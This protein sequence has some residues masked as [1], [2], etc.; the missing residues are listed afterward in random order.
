[1]STYFEDLNNL[2]VHVACLVFMF[3][4]I[5]FDNLHEVVMDKCSVVGMNVVVLPTL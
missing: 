5:I 3:L 1:M 2:T 4:C